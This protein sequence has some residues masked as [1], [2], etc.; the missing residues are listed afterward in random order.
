MADFRHLGSTAP[1][2]EDERLLTGRGRF[3]D[4]IRV[5]GAL[6]ACFVRSP[7]A[8]ARILGI[9]AAAA[10]ELPGVAGVFTGRDLAQWTTRHRMAP[11]IAG[12]HPVEMDTLPVDKVRFHG[13]PVACVLA[14][15]RYLAEDAAERVAV[16]YEVLPA[17]SSLEQALD[18]ASPRVD[19]TLTSNLLSTSRRSTATCGRACAKR[20][21]WW[22]APSRSTARRTCRSRRAAASPCGTRAGST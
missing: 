18:P 19:E 7:H 9:D 20:T 10:L 2:R 3:V 16:D 1:R 17:V 12:L 6:H 8:H 5:P 14:T 15:D 11:P 13:D 4:D 22:R 21:A